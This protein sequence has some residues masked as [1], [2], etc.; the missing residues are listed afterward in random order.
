MRA[1]LFGCVNWTTLK[2]YFPLNLKALKI[3]QAISF[4][5]YILIIKL[6][7]SWILFSLKLLFETFTF[8]TKRFLSLIW[9]QIHLSSAFNSFPFQK[10]WDD[11]FSK[12]K[13]YFSPPFHSSYVLQFL[14]CIRNLRDQENVFCCRYNCQQHLTGAKC[15]W[16][17]LPLY[18]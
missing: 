12:E 5:S 11:V 15:T 17:V 18:G 14:N 8:P 16:L 4:S 7:P 3:F 9:L 2:L 1:T 10:Y 6:F 13:V